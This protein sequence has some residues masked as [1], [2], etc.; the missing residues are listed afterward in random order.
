MTPNLNTEPDIKVSLKDPS[1]ALP[2]DILYH[3][4]ST[5]WQTW[6]DGMYDSASAFDTNNVH[7]LE[8]N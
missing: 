7:S 2:F 5:A 8:N 6:Y 1:D 3:T 4:S